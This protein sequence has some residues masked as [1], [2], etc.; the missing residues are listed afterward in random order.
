MISDE[1]KIHFSEIELTPNEVQEVVDNVIMPSLVL[2]S[3]M[4]SRLKYSKHSKHSKPLALPEVDVPPGATWQD[5]GQELRARWLARAGQRCDCYWCS[6]YQRTKQGR[7][8]NYWVTVVACARAGAP[9]ALVKH[10]DSRRVLSR[11]DRRI[12]ADLLDATFTGE[13]QA[14]LRPPGRPKHVAA[15]ACANVALKFYH[16][17]KALNRRWKIR[18]WGHSDEM[19]DE[20][21]R[22]ALEM[23]TAPRVGSI[24]LPGRPME[25]VPTFEKIRELMDRPKARR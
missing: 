8:E 2:S 16:D 15:Q 23:H 7:R 6:V 25:V 9:S 10:L 21:C 3:K 12:L 22:I 5:T 24:R 13:V 4:R 20:S 18:D 19:R 11:S 14:A 1:G 17:W